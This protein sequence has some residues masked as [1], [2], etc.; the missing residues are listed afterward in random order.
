MPKAITRSVAAVER[1]GCFSISKKHIATTAN[2]G[3][4]PLLKSCIF[5]GF[6][7]KNVAINAINASFVISPGMMVIGPSCIHLTAPFTSFP[8]PATSKPNKNM[9]PPIPITARFLMVLNFILLPTRYNTNPAAYQTIFLFK[10]KYGSKP[11]A[12]FLSA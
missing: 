11:V 3:S 2:M 8:S 9:A 6:F 4:S 1:F 10:K 12:S 5:S 7:L